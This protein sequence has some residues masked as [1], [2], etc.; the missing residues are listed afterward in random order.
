M[1]PLFANP[2][3]AFLLRT[4]LLSQTGPLAPAISQNGTLAPANVSVARIRN[5]ILGL[6]PNVLYTQ[7]SSDH[8]QKF[9]LVLTVLLKSPP[10]IIFMQLWSPLFPR[11]KLHL[12][13]I[14]DVM[15][16]RSV[17]FDSGIVDGRK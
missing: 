9:E 13:V 2:P 14:S 11:H 10:P 3:Q 15:F 6:L 17:I 5:H 12:E 7:L 8:L 16:V 1:F 4:P